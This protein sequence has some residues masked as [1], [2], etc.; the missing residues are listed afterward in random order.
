MTSIDSITHNSQP[1]IGVTP[2]ADANASPQS[3]DKSSTIDSIVPTGDRSTVSTLA[4]QLSDAAIRANERY[5]G[6]TKQ[7]LAK[8]YSD[9]SH[10]LNGDSYRANKFEHDG[11]IPNTDDPTLLERARS[12][13]RYVNGAGKN[14]FTGMSRDQ[15]ALITYDD[16]GS[17]T[18]NER[19][20]AKSEA[21]NQESAW[22][23]KVV[24]E[25]S[26][27]R[28]LTGK[29]T[30]ATKEILAHFLS[31]PAIEQ[32]QY[33]DG[34]P[35]RLQQWIDEDADFTAHAAIEIGRV[36]EFPRIAQKL[37]EGDISGFKPTL[38]SPKIGDRPTLA[39]PGVQPTSDHET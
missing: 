7:Q 29:T 34:Y 18:I 19:K 15:L 4:S 3:I 27:E 5:A 6:L 14:P 8:V 28:D 38:S 22:R 31:L 24:A 21:S 32:T 9:T 16:S 20:A 10:R 23:K 2:F 1:T 39:N 17:F 30:H 35:A 12:A 11:E 33:D 25:L 37:L 26:I 36:K 13:T